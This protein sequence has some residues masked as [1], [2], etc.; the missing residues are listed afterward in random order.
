MASRL[1]LTAGEGA[2]AAE[3]EAAAGAAVPPPL[4][5]AAVP[6][7]A[8]AAGWLRCG[9]SCPIIRRAAWSGLNVGGDDAWA[10]A[11]ELA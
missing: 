8:A 11:V 3:A 2:G 1:G 7:D 6:E 10:T 5:H 9:V 4:L